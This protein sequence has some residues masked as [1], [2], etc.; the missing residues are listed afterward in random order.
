MIKKNTISFI[1]RNTCQ[2]A[3]E[4]NQTF[5][6]DRILRVTP[7]HDEPKKKIIYD[8]EQKCYFESFW[9]YQDYVVEIEKARCYFDREF[10]KVQDL[11]RRLTY[12]YDWMRFR[13]D[14]SGR[15]QV[16][17]NFVKLRKDW[18][19]LKLFLKQDY[20]GA[21][22][23][24]YLDKI[25]DQLDKDET[26]ISILNNY[27][28][29]ALLFPPIPKFHSPEWKHSRSILVAD[30]TNVYLTE[31]I[32]YIGESDQIKEYSIEAENQNPM[33][34]LLTFSGNIKMS[35]RTGLIEKVLV[36][37]VY[38]NNLINDWTFSI[39]ELIG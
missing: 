21:M 22:T 38:K 17:N 6:F 10:Y 7:L 30:E 34:S 16:L 36:N 39:E 3:Y 28:Y 25:T 4:R 5:R 1:Q 9:A 32:K 8:K 29:Y 12:R 26:Y 20:I 31:S 37:V 24:V 35:K 2:K 18:K 33:V 11:H 15:H 13:I 19:E 14:T 23:E 27:L